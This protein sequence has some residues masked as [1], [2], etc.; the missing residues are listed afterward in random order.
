MAKRVIILERLPMNGRL[1]F[2][3]AMWADVPSA[4]QAFYADPNAKSVWTGATAEENAAIAS[5]AV[6]EQVAEYQ[7]RT[8]L[9]TETIAD[10][11]AALQ[12]A[13]TAFQNQVT[14]ADVKWSRY[15]TNWDGTTW[16]AGG[17]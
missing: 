10:V 16:T 1:A 14:N 15:G 8:S 12:A 7:D 3:Y 4:R 6:L 9:A 5:G 17:A 2:R 13:W 11:R